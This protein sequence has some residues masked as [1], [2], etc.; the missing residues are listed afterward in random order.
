MT[1][2]SERARFGC[3]I[4]SSAVATKSLEFPELAFYATGARPRDPEPSAPRATAYALESA[5]D[6]TAIKLDMEVRL[7]EPGIQD[8]DDRG[9]IAAFCCLVGV[10]PRC[11]P[12]GGLFL[13]HQLNIACGMHPT[14]G[15]VVATGRY[16][17]G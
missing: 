16:W 11:S 5:M 1:N 13:R 12:S 17:C 9:K 3:G 2:W 7:I 8:R 14:C 10:A 4:Q 15:C 6:E